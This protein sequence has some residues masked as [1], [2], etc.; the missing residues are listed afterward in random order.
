MTLPQHLRAARTRAGMTQET[1]SEFSGIARSQIA[2]LESDKEVGLTLKTMIRLAK[3]YGC[4]LDEL[5]GY[6]PPR[7]PEVNARELR[8]VKLLLSVMRSEL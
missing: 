1:A 2:V 8:A 4:T 3:C 6:A 7:L 5:T